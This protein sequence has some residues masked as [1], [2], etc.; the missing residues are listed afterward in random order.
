VTEGG[1][2]P[3]FIPAVV[4]LA[5]AL[6]LCVLAFRYLAAITAPQ[7]AGALAGPAAADILV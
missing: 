2:D 1:H 6:P 7:R 5:V 3:L 4:A